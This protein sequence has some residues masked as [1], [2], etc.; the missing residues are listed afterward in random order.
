MRMFVGDLERVSTHKVATIGG[1]GH[2]ASGI[3]T[4]KW[5]WRDD[6]G[7]EY[8][9]LIENVLFFPQSPINILSITSFA[10][11]LKDTKGTGIL[12]LQ[13]SSKFFW[14]H[15]K[16]SR[17]IR[18]PSSNLPELSINEGFS[19]ATFFRGFVSKAINP[20]ISPQFSCNLTKLEPC[21]DDDS[22]CCHHACATSRQSLSTEL[23]EVGETLFYSKNGY[24]TLVKVIALELDDYLVL[25]FRVAQVNG[26]EFVTTREHLRSPSNPDIGWIPSTVPEYKAASLDLSDEE[27]SRVALPVHLSPLQQEFLSLHNRLLPLPSSVMLRLSKLGI[28]PRR[29]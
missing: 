9:Y 24:N 17:T 7:Q 28:L 3:G 11:Q 21:E 6:T 15:G 26:D 20:S 5:R 16:F 4:V 8:Q 23:F 18:H 12:T 19:L 1:K 2:P 14:D 22:G 29:F 25:R 27:I 10:Q 13:R